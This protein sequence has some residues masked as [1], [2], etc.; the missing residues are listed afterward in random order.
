M[1]CRGLTERGRRGRFGLAAE[2]ASV[3]GVFGP[4]ASGKSAVAEAVAD[5]LGTEVVSADAMQVYSGLPILTNQPARPTRL[6]SIR[7]LDE[8]MSVGEYEGLAH[9]V[10]DELVRANGVAVVAGG[11]GLYLRAALTTLDLPPAPPAGLRS[12]IER[13]VDELGPL[14]A[15]AHLAELDARAAATVHRNDHRRVVRA[16]ELAAMGRSLAPAEG[17]LWTAD[18][19]HPTLLVGL[20]LDLDHLEERIRRRAEEMISRGALSEALAAPAASVTAIH[21]IGLAELRELDVDAALEA[22]VRRT[23]RYAA[24]QRKWL[25]RLPLDLTIDGALPAADLA[26]QIVAASGHG[27][28]AGTV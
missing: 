3:I 16:L 5:R 26:D 1:A 20:D 25:R 9:A 13:L 17:R 12:E 28:V 19:R 4:T 27:A 2:P 8:T 23:R 11:T 15:H 6:V 22:I 18:M 21:V 7:E 10:I 14:G 24:Y